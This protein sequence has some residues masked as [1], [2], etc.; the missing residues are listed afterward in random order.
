MWLAL[1]SG[2][3]LHG[4]NGTQPTFHE[5]IECFGFNEKE[6]SLT[7]LWWEMEMEGGNLF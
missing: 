2:S 5:C 4:V 6:S 3:E 7:V 1:L